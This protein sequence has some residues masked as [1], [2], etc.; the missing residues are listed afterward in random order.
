MDPLTMM[1]LMGAKSQLIDMPRY[2]QQM[3]LAATTQRLSPWTHMQATLP[4][5]PNG[6]NSMLQGY[7]T[8]AMMK[9]GKEQ[10][11]LDSQLK[12]AMIEKF[13]SDPSS[14]LDMNAGM[15]NHSM[16]AN[17]QF[18]SNPFPKMK[19]YGTDF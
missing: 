19:G 9:A 16:G 4:D 17:L 18:D 3:H 15:G 7:T 11:D 1:L 10:A 14:V 12:Q 5:Q 2:K 8:G 13:K 6:A